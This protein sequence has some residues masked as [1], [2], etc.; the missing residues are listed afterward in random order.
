MELRIPD[1]KPSL[2]GKGDC[3]PFSITQLP[4]AQLRELGSR[5][6]V[7]SIIDERLL[8]AIN[9]AHSLVKANVSMNALA[10]RRSWLLVGKPG[11]GKSSLARAIPNLWAERFHQEALLVQVLSHVIPSGEKGGTQ[12]NIVR[13]FE[14]LGELAST[15]L[16]IFGVIDELETLAGSRATANP[17]TN[18]QDAIHGVNAFIEGLD[19]S[20]DAHK[21]LFFLFTSNQHC[22]IDRAIT[23]R[24]DF[25]L[26][27]E[28]P[29]ANARLA[30]LQDAI[31]AIGTM[32][33]IP[34]VV[35]T[36]HNE[37]WGKRLGREWAEL[38]GLTAGLS[39]RQLRHLIVSGLS[40]AQGGPLSLKD[41]I[42]A[43]RDHKNQETHHRKYGGQYVH[44]YQ[45]EHGQ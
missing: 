33:S 13:L 6:I 9:I 32:A 40:F 31:R 41:L 42:L 19:H 44:D 12:K 28:P 14:Q 17:A 11:C 18:P 43:A 35:T 7:P 37:K 25:S 27:I 34:A 3:R 24:V 22:N 8:T 21:N 15:G 23:E 29:D 5:I 16:I 30:I 36:I 38:V 39:A 26:L 2:N 10:L 20:V 1:T 4:N 45:K